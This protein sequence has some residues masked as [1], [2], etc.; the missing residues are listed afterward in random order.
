MI[1][2]QVYSI[3]YPF[4]TLASEFELLAFVLKHLSNFYSN[5]KKGSIIWYKR[6]I[7]SLFVL[8]SVEILFSVQFCSKAKMRYTQIEGVPSN[9]LCLVVKKNNSEA[10]C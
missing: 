1:Y 7:F 8:N 6:L 9:H 5:P 3:L 4:T 10:G 2:I